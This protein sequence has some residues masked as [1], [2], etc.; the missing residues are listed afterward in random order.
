MRVLTGLASHA[1]AELLD[2]FKRFVNGRTAA[3]RN[4]VAIQHGSRNDIK[5]LKSG[6][7]HLQQTRPCGYSS[8]F[9]RNLRSFVD[10]RV[11]KS[12]QIKECQILHKLISDLCH[13]TPTPQPTKKRKTPKTHFCPKCAG[14]HRPHSETC[15]KQRKPTPRISSHFI[16]IS[17]GASSSSSS[18]SS[19][20]STS[21]SSLPPP[22]ES[23]STSSRSSSSSSSTSTS[24]S[25]L[26]PPKESSSTS[27]R[28]SSSRDNDH[29]P[30]QGIFDQL[31]TVNGDHT[32]TGELV[33][34]MEPSLVPLRLDGPPIDAV[35]LPVPGKRGSS[36]HNSHVRIGTIP[37]DWGHHQWEDDGKARLQGYTIVIGTVTVKD[38]YELV[39]VYTCASACM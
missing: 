34:G 29:W 21:S 14:Q 12:T 39:C 24:S 1:D 25:P 11:T 8:E 4:S 38:V 18:S 6:V 28:S 5:I 32:V 15:K 3:V 19:S 33:V 13:P 27:S 9:I 31:I 2:C 22:N 26:P 20:T 36:T 17:E 35:V 16:R 30:D 37:A 7:R 23:S 10:P